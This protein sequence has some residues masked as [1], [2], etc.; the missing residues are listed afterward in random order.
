M[1]LTFWISYSTQVFY[2]ALLDNDKERLSQ[3][4]ESIRKKDAA[5]SSIYK[6]VPAEFLRYKD[7]FGAGCLS[8]LA[9]ANDLADADTANDLDGP[10]TGVKEGVETA[11][12]SQ[13]QLV[14]TVQNI[15]DLPEEVKPVEG[16]SDF[17]DIMVL[18]RKAQLSSFKPFLE[19]IDRARSTFAV[20]LAFSFITNE[21]YT[22]WMSFTNRLKDRGFNAES[23][24]W[25]SLLDDFFANVTTELSVIHG[26]VRGEQAVARDPMARMNVTRKTIFLQQQKFLELLSAWLRSVPKSI[27]KA[28]VVTRC[29]EMLARDDAAQKAQAA[30]R[31]PPVIQLPVLQQQ[32]YVPPPQQQQQY[33]QP[34]QQFGQQGGQPP[35]KH[36]AHGD[37]LQ[38]DE[39]LPG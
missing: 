31:V 16:S 29:E 1:D 24:G 12:L 5:S 20:L 15:A 18:F 8:C 33:V 2:A 23:K 13:S 37:G 32:Q 10:K 28:T 6:A 38:V 14:M 11:I 9:S 17:K 27:N 30:V 22:L 21:E 7:G 25:S 4:K 36:V 34:P 3:E 26:K 19:N 35:K 39:Q